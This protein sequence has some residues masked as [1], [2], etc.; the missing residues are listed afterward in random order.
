MDPAS[1]EKYRSRQ[2]MAD[3]PQKPS[4]V[5]CC[6]GLFHRPNAHV[7]VF[8]TVFSSSATTGVGSCIAM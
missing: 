1:P 3:V 6:D 4:R 5:H 2:A 7:L 8:C